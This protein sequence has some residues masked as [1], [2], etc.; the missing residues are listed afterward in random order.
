MAQAPFHQFQAIRFD[1]W[2]SY[3]LQYAKRKRE[4][5]QL[6]LKIWDLDPE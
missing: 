5:N 2:T 4:E 6:G 3:S 1:I